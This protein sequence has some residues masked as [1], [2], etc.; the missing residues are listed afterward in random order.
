MEFIEDRVPTYPGRVELTPVEGQTNVFDVVRADDPVIPGSPINK[1]LLNDIYELANKDTSFN[2]NGSITEKD[3]DTGVSLTTVF[4]DDGS[5][6]ETMRSKD[7]K[8]LSK[9]TSFLTDG[10]IKEVIGE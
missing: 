7:G 1:K 9:T 10:S 5:I 4:N 6:T 2:A 3:P 8:T